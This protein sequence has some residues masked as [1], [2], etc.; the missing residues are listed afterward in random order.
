[1]LPEIL[2]WFVRLLVLA[3]AAAPRTLWTRGLA[4]LVFGA[5]WFIVELLLLTAM[6][7]FAGRIV[8]GERRALF[9]DAF[10]IALLGTILSA[11]FT[12]FIPYGLIAML[13][14]VFTWLLLIKRLYKTGWLGAIA[15]SILASIIFIGI[16]FLLALIFGTLHIIFEWMITSLS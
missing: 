12:A 14:S 13:L 9:T 5:A 15:I 4:N 2:I 3:A 1:M 11:A 7:Y 16:L 10:I 6:L 8:V